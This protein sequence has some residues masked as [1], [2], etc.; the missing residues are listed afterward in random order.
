M[1]QRIDIGKQRFGRLVALCRVQSNANGNVRWLCQ[2]DCGNQTVVDSYALRHHRIVSCG[3]YRSEASR[4]RLLAN[5][6]TAEQIG[7]QKGLVT[8]E[9][10]PQ[11]TIHKSIRNRSGMIGI[12]YSEKTKL[13][14]ARMMRHGRYVLNQSFYDRA[15]AVEARRR[16]EE[17][18]LP[19]QYW[20][21]GNLAE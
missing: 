2:C 3:C 4:K 17:K 14:T 7:N 5:Q 20:Q 6:E 13:W 9:G 16:A 18:Y 12:S 11:A 21:K 8:A 1:A 19:E 15:A 10:I